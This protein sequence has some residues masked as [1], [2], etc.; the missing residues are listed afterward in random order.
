M[1]SNGSA[2]S[3][4]AMATRVAGGGSPPLHRVS[5]AAG[6]SGIARAGA[7]A[8]F[9]AP[10]RSGVGA[11]ATNG[12]GGRVGRGVAARPAAEWPGV[13]APTTTPP[14]FT[15]A[16][17][18]RERVVGDEGVIEAVVDHI[19]CRHESIWRG[20][21][22]VAPTTVCAA[23]MRAGSR[24]GMRGLR[25]PGG[26]VKTGASVRVPIG[27]V[28][29]AFGF[30]PCPPSSF[31][32]AAAAGVDA[33]TLVETGMPVDRATLLEVATSTEPVTLTEQDVYK[34]VDAMGGAPDWVDD[35]DDAD[36]GVDESDVDDVTDEDEEEEQAEFERAA[37]ALIARLG[38]A[39]RQ[40]VHV[41]GL[42]KQTVAENK[43][44]RDLLPRL[45]HS[46][47]DVAVN[48][49]GHAE[50]HHQSPTL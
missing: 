14:R 13:G 7:T 17:G 8:V 15:R 9:K 22:V 20:A 32:Q 38:A 50:H 41:G 25:T 18:G 39:H 10:R 30:S 28:V 26:A 29:P 12:A 27:G 46:S 44:M 24:T 33:V 40:V 43:V 16:A 48:V 47:H 6:G 23:V 37:S 21:P 42:L 45:Q 11:A 19:A 4:V 2:Y 1:V 3:K 31:R 49:T 34:F 35:A 5:G 36:S